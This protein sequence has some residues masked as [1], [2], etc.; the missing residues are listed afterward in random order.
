MGGETGYSFLVLL[1][2]YCSAPLQGKEEGGKKYM[3]LLGSVQKPTE[4][5]YSSLGPGVPSI[6]SHRQGGHHLASQL[7]SQE[8]K[9]VAKENQGEPLSLFTGTMCGALTDIRSGD[10]DTVT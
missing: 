8:K 3:F 7:Q 9:P 4:V 2:F 10:A 5:Q 1:L 6:E